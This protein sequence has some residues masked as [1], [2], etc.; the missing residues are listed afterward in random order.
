MNRKGRGP[1]FFSLDC[2]S[3]GQ[4]S[5]IDHFNS[6]VFNEGK[7]VIQWGDTKRR[8]S[9]LFDLPLNQVNFPLTG[10]ISMRFSSCMKVLK[11]WDPMDDM[12]WLPLSWDSRVSLKSPIMR[13][14]SGEVLW[15]AMMSSHTTALSATEQGL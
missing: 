3:S 1:Q 5:D 10:L 6:E 15:K 2:T 12:C 14:G 9:L 11:S 7:V 8:P 4:W 13:H